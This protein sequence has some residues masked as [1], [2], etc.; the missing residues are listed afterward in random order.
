MKKG[1]TLVEILVVIAIVSVLGVLI[2]TIFTRTLRGSNKSQIIGKIK[3]NGQ[4]VLETMD[5]TVRDSDDVVCPVITSP[6]T[7][8]TSDSLMVIKNGI[9]TRYRFILPGTVNGLIQ[10]DNPVKQNVSGTNREETDSEFRDRVC[11]SA[12]TL[13]SPITLTDTK[14]DTGVSVN[15]VAAANGEPDC[16][17]NPIFKRD[18]SAGFMDQVTI[19]FDLR[20]GVQA[21]QAVAGQIEAV[22]F[23]TTIQLR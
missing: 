6:A 5:K 11:F 4:S 13:V 14:S 18:R 20:P 22:S 3:Q 1:F 12:D 16:N 19:K 21:S 15:C 9:Y 10:Q 8:V 17:N 2:L 7:V 23:Q